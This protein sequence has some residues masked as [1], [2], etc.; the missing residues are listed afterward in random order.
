MSQRHG[1]LSYDDIPYPS[2]PF[3]QTQPDHLACLA[4]L[5]G[6]KP[7]RADQCRVLELGCAS[8]GNL[9]PLAVAYPESHFIGVDF[10]VR[11]IEEGNKTVQALGLRNIELRQASITDIDPSWGKFDYV[12]AHGV[13]SWVPEPVQDA[14]LR[15]CAENL[16]EDGVGYVSYNTFPGW[17]M[18]GMIRD[19]MCYH[20]SR[21]KDKQPLEKVAQARGLLHFLASAVKNERSAYSQL[22]SAELETLQKHSD[23]YLYHEHLEE[24]NDPIYF[25][26][27]NERLA[28]KKLRY[29]GESDF[30]VMVHANLPPDVQKV[31]NDVAPNLI[32]MEQYLDFLRNRTF[33]QTLLCREH[34]RP[35]YTLHPD[36][37]TAY[38]FASP[39]KPRNPA[40]DL[41]TNA[42]EDFRG[43]GD[44]SITTPD[45]IVKA[46]MVVLSENWPRAVPFE[47]LRKQ[48]RARISPAPPSEAQEKEDRLNLGKAFLTAYAGGGTQL[49]ELWMHPPKFTNRPSDRP[50]ASPLARYQAH[51][52][53]QVF[54][55][56]HQI[57]TVSEFDRQLLPY[58][59]G[60]N[61]KAQLLKHMVE[62]FKQG[63]LTLSRNGQP[64]TDEIKGRQILAQTLE[65]QL[66]ALA[67]VALLVS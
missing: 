35:S 47:E 51:G 20:V 17:H 8:G 25:F 67:S 22:L 53:T 7:R 38:K 44:L 3:A 65:S 30:R 28:Q 55:L 54:S 59:D 33:R 29:L 37:M 21:H 15:V 2:N 61:T 40:P 16:E 9:I 50:L 27:F 11:Q 45:P 23:A 1:N 12:T 43:M 41:A 5:F 4:T 6:L 58:L 31:L 56:K 18:R 52:S 60:T 62:R 19:M 57:V 66:P 42:P 26:E 49:L 13:Y 63:R 10:S 36:H 14:M 32:Q 48:A 64:I 46:A 39:L 34:H 24:H